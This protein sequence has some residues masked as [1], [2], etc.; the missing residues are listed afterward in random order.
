MWIGRAQ[1]HA[2]VYFTRIFRFHA[3]ADS[4][5]RKIS[6]QLLPLSIAVVL[7]PLA[8]LAGLRICKCDVLIARV[9]IRIYYHHVRLLPPEALVIKQPKSNRADGADIVMKSSARC[10]KN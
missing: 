10:A 1:T 2:R 3:H 8:A 7:S 6:I 5:Q 4:P 9:I